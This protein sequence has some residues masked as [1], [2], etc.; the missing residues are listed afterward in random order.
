VAVSIDKQN[1]RIFVIGDILV[2]YLAKTSGNALS[3]TRRPGGTAFN[4]AV[5]FQEEGLAPIIVGSV[6]DDENGEFI[7]TEMHDRGLSH[8]IVRSSLPTGE[9]VLIRDRVLHRRLINHDPSAN[10]V[11]PLII[12]RTLQDLE[13]GPE[14]PIFMATHALARHPPADCVK[15]FELVSSLSEFIIIDLLPHDLSSYVSRETVQA[16]LNGRTFLLVSQLMTIR[17]LF[18]DDPHPSP[19][20]SMDDWHSVFDNLAP[21]IVAVRY[22][23]LGSDFECVAEAGPSGHVH[24]RDQYATQFESSPEVEQVGFGDRLTARL[25]RR[26]I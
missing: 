4:A 15:F 7:Q 26:L 3:G 5:A 1:R 20:P 17:G 21:R 23:P 12:A 13:P 6:G 19:A 25:A 14:E 10:M 22:G 9:C 24:L 18:L 11:D 16:C 8:R 2:D